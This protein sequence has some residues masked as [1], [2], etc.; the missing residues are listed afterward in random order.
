MIEINRLFKKAQNGDDKAF[1]KLF[2]TYE[3]EVYR[4]AYIYVKNEEDALDIVQETAYRS[5]KNFNSLKEI[6][7]FKTWLIRITINCAIDHIRKSNNVIELIPEYEETLKHND[8]DIPLKLTLNELINTLDENEKSVI[9]LKYYYD[10]TF[11]EISKTL[12]IPLGSGKSILYRALNKL[13]KKATE[14]SFYEE[15][16]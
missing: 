10:Y 12:K 8:E 11:K 14:V 6:S 5:F 2:Q 1:L 15:D 3:K 13:R 16:N 4:I 9:I 7:Y